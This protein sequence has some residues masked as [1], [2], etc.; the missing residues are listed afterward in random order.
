MKLFFRKY[1]QGQPI[2]ILHGLFGASD[3]WQT[4]GKK[5]AE[6]YEV[7]LV[8]LR[9]HG[10]S[11]QS[12]IWNYEV[13]SADLLELINDEKIQNPIVIG[14]SMGGKAAMY[15]ALQHPDKV[16]KLVVIDISPK[17][18]AVHHQQ[19]LDALQAV[20]LEKMT[21][22]KQAE[23]IIS[24]FISDVSTK[25]FLLK[26]L[27]WR[28]DAPDKLAWRFNLNVIA[29]NINEVGMETPLPKKPLENLS[30]LFIRGEKSHYISESDFELVKKYFF[31]VEIKTI[32]GAGH[33]I[34][35]DQPQQSYDVLIAFFTA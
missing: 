13:M 5:L 28:E 32:S 21:S 20:D 11:P 23:E 26:N 14:H 12:E 27:Y 8:D 30:T 24:K 4:L 22:R 9:N 35:A 25:Q 1:G 17:F 19:I 34:H 10:H 3:N 29:K 33:W 6:N 18:Y 7:Y 16:K 15:F 31:D 2:I